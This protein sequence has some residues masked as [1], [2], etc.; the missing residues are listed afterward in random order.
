MLAFTPLPGRVLISFDPDVETTKFGII[1]PLS[2]K[3]KTG[4]VHAHNC[5]WDEVDLTNKKVVADRWAARPFT[6][7]YDGKEYLFHIISQWHV[8]AI[9]ED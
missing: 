5:T 9:I 4:F 3:P 7:N 2:H 6:I 8:F 1:L